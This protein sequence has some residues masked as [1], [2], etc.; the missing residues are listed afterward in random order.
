MCTCW[1][2]TPIRT[3]FPLISNFRVVETLSPQAITFL[4]LDSL[5]RAP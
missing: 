5:A 4:R 2:S 3:W 1:A